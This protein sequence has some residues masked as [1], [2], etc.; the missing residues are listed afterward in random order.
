MPARA[1]AAR[2][3]A[4][5]VVGVSPAT[6][7]VSGV[8]A[9]GRATCG[10]ATSGGATCGGATCAICPNVI[11]AGGAWRAKSIVTGPS[12]GG[13]GTIRARSKGVAAGRGASGSRSGAGCAASKGSDGA[14]F[15]KAEVSSVI[16]PTSAWFA[17]GTFTVGGGGAA[18][19]R[20]DRAGSVGVADPRRSN[21]VAAAKRRTTFGSRV[22]VA[23][24]GLGLTPT[25]GRGGGGTDEA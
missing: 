25:W 3:N 11:G 16:V 4:P 14:S 19:S 20:A 6:G 9:C 18:G 10:R 7:A 15:W 21:G 1:S 5:N 12:G 24:S 22:A 17:L 23:P 2:K 13:G 8:S